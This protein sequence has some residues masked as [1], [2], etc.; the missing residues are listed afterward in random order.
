LAS[1]FHSYYNAC[2]FILDDQDLTQARLTVIHATKQV[3]INGLTILGVS[4]PES[5]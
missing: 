2:P 3:L 1:Q 4:S 5:M